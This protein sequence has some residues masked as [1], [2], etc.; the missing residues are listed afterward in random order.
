MDRFLKSKFKTGKKINENFLSLTYQGTTLS[1]EQPVI[2]KIYK[3]GTL[4]SLL[5]K[6]MKQKVR[7][8]QEKIH[9]IIVPLLDGDYGWQ[10]FYYV[11]PNIKGQTLDEII[12][13]SKLTLEEAENIFFEVC[14]ALSAAHKVGIVHGALKATNV[15]VDEKGVK[16]VDFVIE[17]DVKESLPQ[18]SLA[19]LQNDECLS[20]EEIAGNKAG[21]SSDIFAAGLV[22]YKMLTGLT[23]FSSGLDKLHGKA[24]FSQGIP[25]YIRDILEKALDPDPLL[26]FKDILDLKESIKLKSIVSKK[27]MFDLPPIEL[28]NTPHPKDVEI[29]IIEKERKKSFFLVVVIILSA[30]AG[31][32]YAIIT[33]LMA[34]Q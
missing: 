26:R 8:L 25:H 18:K 12:K 7:L 24:N 2:I 32:I 28:E 30:L 1:G 5:I 17:G 9:P 19:V 20:P 22:F 10:G 14:D 34:G 29:Q 15:F 4:N 6:N 13:T 21:P 16:L 31:I 23:P 33:S 11:R 3:R 27:M